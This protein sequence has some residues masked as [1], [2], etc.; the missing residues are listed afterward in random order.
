VKLPWFGSWRW[1]DA[2]SVYYIPF[3]PTSAKQTIA[4]YHIPT[5]TSRLITDPVKQPLQIAN[6]DWSVSPDGRTIAF[7][8]AL[9][10]RT[11]LLT[12]RG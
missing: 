12:P 9:D 8:N 2:D 3:D 4:Y 7:L 5:G 10:R 11:W 1:R 6:G